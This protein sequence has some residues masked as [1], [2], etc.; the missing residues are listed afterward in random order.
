M[1]WLL[2]EAPPGSFRSSLGLTCSTG[3]IHTCEG[4]IKSLKF[5]KVYAIRISIKGDCKGVLRAYECSREGH[6]WRTETS[7]IASES[8]RPL[9]SMSG[10]AIHIPF[11]R[12]KDEKS[13]KGFKM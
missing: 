12:D 9:P 5:V 3:F 11:R 13:N 2:T 4:V 8:P 7:Y 1:K 10:Y 6:E